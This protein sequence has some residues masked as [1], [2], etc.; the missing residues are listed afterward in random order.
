MMGNMYQREFKDTGIRLSML[1]M[2]CMR[3]PKKNPDS[4]EVDYEKA[5]EI[6]DYAY[7]HG[8][9]YYDTAYM[10]HSGDSE[11]FLGQAMKKYPRDSFYLASKMP[12]WM[13]NCK[14]DVEKIFEEQLKKCG[15][16][17]FDFYLMHSVQ[18]TNWDKY[19][20]Y[21]VYDYLLEQ[22]KKGRIRYL[23]FS[24]HDNPQL[25]TEIVEKY[26]FDF[27]QIQCN[28]VDWDGV[29]DAKGQYEVLEK[30]G[31]P[32]I[33]MEPVRG[34]A[35]AAPGEA[36]ESMLKAARPDDSIASWA[37]RFNISKPNTMVVLSGM[38]NMEQI[39]DNVNTVTD[40]EPLSAE[41]EALLAKAGEVYRTKDLVP[42]TGCRYCMDCPFGLDIPKNFS[43]FNEFVRSEDAKAFAE[44]MDALPE[45]MRATGC[46]ACGRCATHCPQLIAIP[47]KMKMIAEKY[48]Q[49]K[50]R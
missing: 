8:V 47:D 21:G 33:V 19:V 35:L 49:A 29:Q 22:K 34:G 44:A 50:K 4:P 30:H 39:M 18:R 27:A 5:Q 43:I 46:R 41:E 12:V 16:E 10:Y 24:F 9:N 25:L 7:A 40:F 11:L 28:Y 42:C 26:Q 14:E 31:L 23:G 13:A 1:G 45:E 32:V 15:V 36:I 3:L 48:E 6:I 20:E 2:G 38:S 17:Y 37:I